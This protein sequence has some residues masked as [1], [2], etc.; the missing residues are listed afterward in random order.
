VTLERNALSQGG[1]MKHP[2]KPIARREGLVVQELP[3]ET[4]VYDLNT[5]KAHCLN[6]SA[7]VVWRSCTGNNSVQDILQ[8]FG[9]RFDHKVTEDFIWLAIDQL[10]EKGL[11]EPGTQRRFPGQSRRQALKA[12]GLASA[13]ALPVIASLVAPSSALAA[14]SCGCTSP[15]SCSGTSCPSTTNCNPGGVCASP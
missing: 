1:K 8:E 14:V 11:L 5:N 6:R 9:S 2:N 3:D 10:N 12:I 7:A 15:A 13:V 4:L